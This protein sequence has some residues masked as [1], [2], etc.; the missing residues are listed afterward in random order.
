MNNEATYCNNC[1][2]YGHLFHQC[3]LPITSI[4][5]IIF[6]IMKDVVP[7]TSPPHGY[8]TDYSIIPANG[9]SNKKV[10]GMIKMKYAYQGME[11][12]ELW[13]I[14]QSSS[15]SNRVGYRIE[16]LMI[17]RKDSLGYI[18]FM[19]GKYSLYN[20][21]YI[22]NMLQQM[23]SKEKE[24]LNTGNFDYLWTLLWGGNVNLSVQ[25]KNEEESSR[26]KFNSLVSGITFK[27]E[28]YS[29]STLLNESL[30]L[31]EKWKDPEWGF[32]KGRRNYHENDYECAIRELCE[33]TG[34]KYEDFKPIQNI[35]PFEETFTGSNFKS[36]KH[37]YFL[38]NMDFDKSMKNVNF[39]KSEVSK[40]K[41]LSYDKCLYHIRPYNLEKRKILTKVNEI[42]TRY[43]FL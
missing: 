2:K 18:D 38:M 21:E 7:K 32:P 22:M 12:E 10:N 36:Y 24:L 19:R 28:F 6:R 8:I 37:K 40:M 16:Y 30:Y 43:L 4:G 23:T 35:Y 26:V 11:G 25:Y 42:L 5:A 27:D 3:H 13:N 9:M 1:G 29:L 31:H 33:E 14:A 34:Y 20:K 17:C 15:I 41:W 39:Q